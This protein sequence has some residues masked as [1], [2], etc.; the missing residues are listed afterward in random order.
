MLQHLIAIFAY[1]NLTNICSRTIAAVPTTAR[2][3]LGDGGL[4]KA[5]QLHLEAQL[6]EALT[7]TPS[8]HAST[9]FPRQPE[10]RHGAIP[11]GGSQGQCIGYTLGEK[12][13][14]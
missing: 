2:M 7:R 12:M 1:S 11:I 9:A 10:D 6:K 14:S 4:M 3:L 8:K 5:I 13:L